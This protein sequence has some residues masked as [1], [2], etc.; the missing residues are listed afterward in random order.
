MVLQDVLQND[1][2]LQ[3]GCCDF[4][5]IIMTDWVCAKG[6]AS[7]SKTKCLHVHVHVLYCIVNFQV[8]EGPKKV[9]H[10]CTCIVS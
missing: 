5:I 10:V 1:V 3:Q 7:H 9:V 4:C 8:L 2:V 6:S